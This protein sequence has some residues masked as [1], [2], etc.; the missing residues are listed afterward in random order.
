MIPFHPLFLVAAGVAAYALLDSKKGKADDE[1]G[2]PDQNDGNGDG[3]YCHRKQGAVD[4]QYHGQGVT[5]NGNTFTL[6][7]LN[8]ENN[9]EKVSPDNEPVSP[10]GSGVGGDDC[11]G[12]SNPAGETSNQRADSNATE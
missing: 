4:S 3:G 1:H 5:D 11:G 8:K 2:N 10:L 12:E 6:D 7:K 9:D